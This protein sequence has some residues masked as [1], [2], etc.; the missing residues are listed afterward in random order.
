MHQPRP[1]ALHG[2][3]HS[4]E[5]A[6]V[7][8][9]L[10]RRLTNIKRTGGQDA[11]KLVRALPGGGV[12]VAMDMGGV[13]K[14]VV[15]APR[16]PHAPED[17]WGDG[18]ARLAVPMLFSGVI[19]RAVFQAGQGVQLR[20]TEQTRR[21]LAHYKGP[22]PGAT[23]SLQRFAIE[24]SQRHSE[25]VP[26]HDVW[27]HSQY[28]QLR[29][30]WFSGRMATLVQIAGGYGRQDSKRLPDNKIERARMVLPPKVEAKIAAQM[31]PGILPGYRGW[32]T[33]SG[34]IQF[35]YK[36]HET[37]G[38]AFDTRRK[39]WLVRV[40]NR[41][42]YAMPLPMVPATTTEAFREYVQEVGDA[43]LEWIIDR[44][45]GMP[46]GEGFPEGSE[47]FEAWRRAGVIIKVCD[48]ADF[49]SRHM[50]YSSAMG[51]SFNDA[52]TTAVNTCYEFDEGDGLQNGRTY[53]LSLRLGEVQPPAPRSALD[54][55]DEAALS[56]YLAAVLGAAPS[57]ARGAALRFKLARVPAGELVARANRHENANWQA[58]A[59]HWDSLEAQPIANHS[60]NIAMIAEGNVWARGQP[61]SHPQIKFP[62]PLMKGCVSHDFGRLEGY[63][64]VPAG[65]IVRCD[66]IMHAYFVGDEL[67]VVK[68]FLDTRKYTQEEENNFDECM[69]VGS[70]EQTIHTGQL[71][72]YGHFYSTDI[73][74]REAFAPTTTRTKIVG[75]DLGYDHTPHFE[76]DH[77]F[78]MVGSIWRNRYFKHET[79]SNTV[80]GR[81]RTI[82]VCVPYFARNGVFNAQRTSTTSEST[83]K[84]R[85][86]YHT[87]DPNSYRY[88][89]Y[90]F[91]WAWVSGSTRGN[92]ANA[93]GASPYPKDGNPVWVMGYNYSPGPCT[94]FADQGDWMGGLPQ[95]YT[96]LI[97]PNKNEWRHSGGGGK[98]TMREFFDTTHKPGKTEGLLHLSFADRLHEV[99]KDPRDGFFTMSPSE[100]GDVFYTDAIKNEAGEAEY[101]S[102]AEA[103]P[104]SPTQRMRW[105]FTRLADH[106]SAHYFIGV[107]NE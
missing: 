88:Y 62:E 22:L 52:G 28:V 74:A 101:A 104:E 71:S 89:T 107:I 103:N 105:G 79:E 75:T 93:A 33:D 95:D 57:G 72:L 30:T 106:K 81:A 16:A 82:A 46:S 64:D 100:F 59:N 13:L 21:R 53:K 37:H 15:H 43:E 11:L 97:H 2:D 36:F 63:P 48:A 58:E 85:A 76:F 35:D 98:P 23:Q 92:M 61:R 4:E 26:S 51:W 77:F 68:Y 12:A 5:D 91:V 87:T 49:Y 80:H 25:F 18:R 40:N 24:Y 55:G 56:R 38:V 9:A 3:L 20:L 44:F 99:N 94:D 65:Y 86:L 29:P 7:V 34:Q 73:D 47:A 19:E 84:S 78:S 31:K 90:D 42:V 96:W 14:A 1:Y 27:L 10:V 102:C 83:R 39:P 17:E 8:D 60:G 54:P 50:G 69:Q 45:G 66:T 41:G 70:W 32:P 6:A 67:K